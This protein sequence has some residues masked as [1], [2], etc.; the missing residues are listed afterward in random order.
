MSNVQTNTFDG[1]MN[2][3]SDIIMV[4]NNQYRYAENV[5]IITDENGTTGV[6]QN[7]KDHIDIVGGK[8]INDDEIVLA[9][10]TINEYGVVLTKVSND[11][12]NIIYRIHYLDDGSVENKIILKAYLGYDTDDKHNSIKMILN[13]ES[14]NNIKLYMS[15]KNHMIR[16]MNILNDK[17]VQG[18]ANVD[19][20]GILLNNGLLDIVPSAN[21]VAPKITGLGYGFHTAGQVQY[22]YA[23]INLQGTSTLISPCSGL[24]QLTDNNPGQDYN[25]IEGQNKGE[26]TGVSVI[27]SIDDIIDSYDI[28]RI[29]RIKYED[30]SEDPTITIADEVPINGN[31]I[32]YED[33][34]D[35]SLSSV[36]IEEFNILY[37]NNFIAA[38]I[39]KKDNRLFAANVTEDSWDVDYDAR[40][41]RVNK[42]KKLKLLSNSSDASIEK[43]LTS[44]IEESRKM[45]QDIPSNHDC[46]NPYNVYKDITDE[47]DYQYTISDKGGI[48]LGGMGLNIDYSFTYVDIDLDTV[49]TASPSMGMSQDFINVKVKSIDNG[50]EP[51]IVKDLEDDSKVSEIQLPNGIYP[52]NYASP[53]YSLYFR[54][55]QRDEI[56][57][58]GI[59]FYN[60]KGVTSPVHWI[61]DI[62]MPNPQDYPAYYITDYIKFKGKPLGIKFDIRNIPEE[63]VGYD[64]VR[65]DRTA[66]DRTIL[67]Q[68]VLSD[69]MNYPHKFID[70][71]D[72]LGN[73]FDYRPAI[74]LGYASLNE[75]GEVDLK[76]CMHT[77]SGFGKLSAAESWYT[78]YRNKISQRLKALISTELDLNAD[79]VIDLLKDC[80]VN[81]LYKLGQCSR[82]VID[83]SDFDLI[84]A[85]HYPARFITTGKTYKT[86]TSDIVDCDLRIGQPTT[87]KISEQ[88][89]YGL[90][91]PYDIAYIPNLIGK[92]YKIYDIQDKQKVNIDIEDA[93]LPDIMTADNITNKIAFY[94]TIDNVSYLNIGHNQSNNGDK[95]LK[96]ARGMYFGNCAVVS[97]DFK[98]IYTKCNTAMDKF[99]FTVAAVNIKRNIYPYG[100]STYSARSNSKY[101]STSSYSNSNTSQVITYGGDTYIGILDHKTC[102][103][104]PKVSDDYNQEYRQLNCVDY[105]PVETTVNVALMN[106]QSTGR[107][108]KNNTDPTTNDSMIDPYLSTT[109]EGGNL[110]DYHVQEKP[111]AAYNDAYS[112]QSKVKTF[113]PD[114]LYDIDNTEFG[115]RILYS[116][117][118]TNGEIVDS[119]SKFRVANY[120]DV[121]SSYGNISVLKTFKDKLLFWQ[122]NSLGVASVNDRSLISDNIGELTL[123]TGGILSRYDYLTIGNGTDIVNDSSI[124]NSESNLYWYDPNKKEIC[125][126]SDSVY[127]LSKQGT[128]QTYLNSNDLYVKDSLYDPRF[129]EIQMIFNDK[130]LVYNE[131]TRSF[132]SFYTYNPSKHLDFLDD[133]VYIKDNIL[134]RDSDNPDSGVICK[135]QYIVNKDPLNTKTFDN[136]YF[137]GVFQDINQMITF[138]EFRTKNQTATIFNDYIDNREDTYRFAIGRDKTQLNKLSYPGRLKG[139]YLVCD[140]TIEC[141]NQDNFNLPNINTTYRYSLV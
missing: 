10:A 21:L 109:I 31:S 137:D 46:I 99:S 118:K 45:L 103:V 97:G 53:F 127:K 37:Y 43:Q 52:R 33:R 20:N 117:A 68:G 78:V 119:W 113:V 91:I 82:G 139:K 79:S 83:V 130:T 114:D 77:I 22:A 81:Y 116:D 64:I 115:N 124:V 4:P 120:M 66:N 104:I 102:N 18:N 25:E 138:S 55:Y 96:S 9:T 87:T 108:A 16:T 30:N 11:G 57:R 63:V 29:Y 12:L 67:L 2:L 93:V 65:C 131:Q 73:E 75:E 6:L 42:Q 128:V 90:Y 76:E 58:F 35:T 74:P 47:D 86:Y 80:Y 134:T 85:G 41:Y 17:Y 44:D 72:E 38:T 19:E 51:C 50:S 56:Y 32:T 89:C 61:A 24:I 94:K 141:Y 84:D 36:T 14:E 54:G 121:D 107:S 34:G 125:A 126:L 62:R 132:S 136:V 133:V 105:I 110:G 1:G 70:I 129:N 49:G 71:G 8:F 48:K 7:I 123:G 106:G 69:I 13:H 122:S 101:I 135:L 88:D 59:V 140:Y 28:C 5:R 27:M 100:G 3:D 112:T 95:T 26:Y 23:L 15:D 92:R 98:N 111:Y 40:S 60:D 39:D